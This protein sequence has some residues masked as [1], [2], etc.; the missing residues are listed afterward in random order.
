MLQNLS[1]KELEELKEYL[2]TYKLDY[3]DKINLP[4]NLTFGVEIEGVNSFFDSFKKD[5]YDR[6]WDVKEE[7]TLI[8]KGEETS[9]PILRDNKESWEAIKYVCELLWSNGIRSSN[10][11]AGHIHYGHDGLIDKDP[12]KL[13]NI[14]KLWAVY[15]RIIYQYSAGNFENYREGIWNYASP[16][17]KYIKKL[18][19]NMGDLDFQLLLRILCHN[20]Y[21]TYGLNFENLYSYLINENLPVRKKNTIEVKV[22]NG[23]L[24]PKKWQNNIRF[25]GSLFTTAVTGKFD[26]EKID[27]MLTELP[28]DI[29]AVNRKSDFAFYT[30]ENLPLALE[31]ADT[32][33]TSDEDKYSFLAQYLYGVNEPKEEKAK[34]LVNH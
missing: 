16:S 26:K 23:T 2:K 32:I 18:L 25:F 6:G 12:E 7:Y 27:R 10:R 9:S 29:S 34:T 22:P 1:K 5:L 3:K 21:V 28:F 11:C 33:F 13:K 8:A 4:E 31:M 24:N 17:A 30:N 14:M 19:D 20:Q 15:E